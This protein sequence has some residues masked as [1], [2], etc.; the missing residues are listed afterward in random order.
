MTFAVQVLKTIDVEGRY[1]DNPADAGG[2]TNH[3]I[4]EAIAR[5]WGY[6]GSMQALT[7]AQAIQIAQEV[8]Y[9]DPAFNLI[10]VIDD[11][12]ADLLF[13]IG[14]N[15][16]P[17]TAGKFVQTAINAL[18]YPAGSLGATLAVDGA[19]GAFTRTALS[20]FYVARGTEGHEVLT[21]MVL[22]QHSV[23]YITLS[24]A[25]SSQ[26]Q[27]EYGWQLN[28]VIGNAQLAAPPSPPST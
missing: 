25:S 16:G 21:G 4:T 2:A 9:I 7:Q 5:A 8:F 20:K 26:K 10:A 24:Q 13:D 6:E 3:G 14:F 22:A 15:A 23:R 12:L 17:A 18:N 27:F 11:P 28:R 1:S 19:L